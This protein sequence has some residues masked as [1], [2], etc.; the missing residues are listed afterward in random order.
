MKTSML[1]LMSALFR[2]EVKSYVEKEY[3]METARFTTLMTAP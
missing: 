2:K 3:K 1:K